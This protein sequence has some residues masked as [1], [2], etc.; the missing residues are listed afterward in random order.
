MPDPLMPNLLPEMR[1]AV[2]RLSRRVGFTIPAV[3]TLAIG[4]GASC[5]IFSVV[6]AVLLRPLPYPD[7]ERLVMVWE[8]NQ[9]LGLPRFSVSP[10]NF[11][12]W[13]EHQKASGDQRVFEHLA[14]YMP[15]A[16]SLSA[17]GEAERV[18]GLRA[19]ADFLPLLGLEPVIGRVFSD[20]EDRPGQRVV[21]L[22]H[23]FWQRRFGSDPDILT[24]SLN[25]NGESYSI[26]GVMAPRLN[27]PEGVEIWVPVAFSDAEAGRRRQRYLS[28]IGRLAPGVTAERAAAEMN[29]VAGRLATEYPASNADWEVVL[30]PL[31]E[32]IVG[33]V[34]QALL[35]LL[36]SVALLLLIPFANVANLM[37]AEATA[38]QREMAVRAAFGADRLRLNALVLSES[39][40]LALLG[41]A[42][43]LVLAWLALRGL[44]L[45]DPGYIPRLGEI[46]IDARVVGVTLLVSLVAGVFFALAAVPRSAL[47]TP[48]EALREGSRA[49][50]GRRGRFARSAL[51]VAQVAV[52]LVLL[53]CAGLL[54]RSFAELFKV[55]AGF[56]PD[57]VV[58]LSVNLNESNYPEIH[59]QG[60]FFQQVMGR[61]EVLPGVESAA[62]ATTLPC[63]DY[64]LTITFATPSQLE[65]D[66]GKFLQAG[67]DAVS[68]EYFRALGIPLIRG[69]VF[70]SG[71]HA[72][73]PPVAVIN[74]TMA[75][76][77]WPGEDPI[78]KF[79]HIRDRNPVNPREIVGIVGDVRHR[80]LDTE[81]RADMYV[82]Y[83][84]S[85]W[86]FMSLMARGPAASTTAGSA[87]LGDAM[88]QE[89]GQ[90]ASNPVL[91]HPRTL[92][93]VISDSVAQPRF[94]MLLLGA[95]AC[96]ALVLSALGVYSVVAYTVAQRTAEI[97]IRMS[98][99]AT[100]R[101][102]VMLVLKNGLGLALCGIVAGLLLG[103][104]STRLLAGLLYGVSTLDPLT[105]VVFSLL[106]LLVACLATLVPARWATRADPMV[107]LRQE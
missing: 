14:I 37:L 8:A 56:D 54:A 26:I 12:D 9:P 62:L 46:S 2:R 100:S 86:F 15:T 89:I 57:D 43:G 55:D 72:E 102:V 85:P 95:F 63:N 106:L 16:F 51:V 103:L 50:T 40:L 22:S 82:S 83:L 7:A 34:R 70:N 90:V 64:S 28:V 91:G 27:F 97:G 58:T 81:P 33:D 18:E 69:R 65:A 93:Q 76:Q 92:R 99:G 60:A 35:V 87:T 68:T 44:V 4:L 6:N 45:H 23:G 5:A 24:R 3:L 105:F 96:A 32:E 78:G 67:Y 53:I 71:D 39:V 38:R 66:P 41:G 29:T 1:F 49:S 84:Q 98:L 77:N 47:S 13:R 11:L 101:Q 36:G 20:R 88:R 94:N 52:A 42:A 74:E 10:A 80:G 75:R 48:A 61:V 17:G 31:R 73:A 104:A 107:A 19:S 30:E 59:Q 25:L 21:V 79:I